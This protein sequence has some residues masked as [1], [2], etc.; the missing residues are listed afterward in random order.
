VGAIVEPPLIV[1]APA[2]AVREPAPEYP[3]FGVIL[4]LR[5]EVV[6]FTATVVSSELTVNAP[7]L[8]VTAAEA[9]ADF[10]ERVTPLVPE[11]ALVRLMFRALEVIDTLPPDEV[12]VPAVGFE[13]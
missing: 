8:A 5:A 10:A 9:T 2:V 3:V 1:T 6:P 7:E 13:I 11:T 4:I 12:I